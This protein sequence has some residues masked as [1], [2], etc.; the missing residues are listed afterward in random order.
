MENEFYSFK[1]IDIFGAEGVGKTTFIK[2]IENN[3]FIEESHSEESKN[4][5]IYLF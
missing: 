1:K 4:L 2:F 5:L 3:T